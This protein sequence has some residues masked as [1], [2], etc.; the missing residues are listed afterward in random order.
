MIE[1]VGLVGFAAT[2]CM[3][4]ILIPPGPAVHT[5]LTTRCGWM[6]LPV[7]FFAAANVP[8]WVFGGYTVID[9]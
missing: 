6:Q 9:V 3:S 8:C 2:A 1:P 7:F 5:S 4:V